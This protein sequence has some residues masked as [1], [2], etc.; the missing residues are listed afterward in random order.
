[1]TTSK[2]LDARVA[3]GLEA[4]DRRGPDDWRGRIDVDRIDFRLVA[5]YTAAMVWGRDYPAPAIGA[6]L[7]YGGTFVSVLPALDALLDPNDQGDLFAEPI[8]L[9]PADKVARRIKHGFTVGDAPAWSTA[10]YATAFQASR[11]EFTAAWQHA[12]R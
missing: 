7:P 5:L 8:I 2:E 3:L 1:M 6:P 9:T 4:L 11:R 10:N 12:L